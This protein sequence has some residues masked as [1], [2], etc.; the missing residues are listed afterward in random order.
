[1][2]FKRPGI[3]MNCFRNV[4]DFFRVLNTVIL[5]KETFIKPKKINNL[6]NEATI[7]QK[8]VKWPN[9][10]TFDE[11]GLKGWYHDPCLVNN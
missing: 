2:T 7:S 4:G 9:L 3:K 11:S 5:K 1:M 10:N 6:S 8:S